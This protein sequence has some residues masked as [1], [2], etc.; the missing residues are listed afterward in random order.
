VSKGYEFSVHSDTGL[1]KLPAEHG[2]SRS[3]GDSELTP[4]HASCLQLQ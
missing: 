4:F 2:T 3:G 1:F